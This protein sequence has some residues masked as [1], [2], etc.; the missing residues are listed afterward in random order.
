MLHK[1]PSCIRKILDD[2]ILAERSGRRGNSRKNRKRKEPEIS[3][4]HFCFPHCARL[5]YEQSPIKHGAFFIS[6]TWLFISRARQEKSKFLERKIKNF[7]NS[8]F[9]WLLQNFRTRYEKSLLRTN[10]TSV[11]NWSVLWMVMSLCSSSASSTRTVR[12]PR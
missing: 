11:G 8:F 10:R 7:A 12:M 9:C 5:S 4:S 3:S 2:S 1:H 6:C